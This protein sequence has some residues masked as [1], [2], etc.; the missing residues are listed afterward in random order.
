VVVAH[1]ILEATIIRDQ[2]SYRELGATHYDQITK[3]HIIRYHWRRL[4]RLGLKVELSQL[5]EAA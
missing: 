5:T 3:D 1:G 4:Q 2:L